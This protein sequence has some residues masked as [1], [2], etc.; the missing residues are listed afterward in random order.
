MFTDAGTI[1]IDGENV[2]DEDK[3]MEDA[4]EAGASD[5]IADDGIFEI[6]TE[7]DDLSAVKEA[8]EGMGYKIESAE[9]DKIP[10]TYVTLESEDDLKKMNLLL[11]KLDEH[12]DVQNVYHNWENEE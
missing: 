12:D 3:L 1:I 5:I 2:A 8:L 6:R 7:P 4:L 11:E 9:P 10:S